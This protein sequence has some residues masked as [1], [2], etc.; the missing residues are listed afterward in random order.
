MTTRFES[1]GRTSLG[2]RLASIINT[3]ERY[4][5]YRVFSREGFPAITALVSVVRPELR[6]LREEAQACRLSCFESSLSTPHLRAYRKRPPD[7]DDLEAEERALD[8]AQ[9]YKSVL[10][11]LSFLVSWPAWT[12]PR[13][14]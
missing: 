1:Y 11:A 8:H 7:F 4:S 2:R 3:P 6:P 5:E 10:Q 12:G 14:W 9:G 13:A